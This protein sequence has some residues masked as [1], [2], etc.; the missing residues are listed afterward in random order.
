MV[1]TV[2]LLLLSMTVIGVLSL[3]VVMTRL[4][5]AG[6][7]RESARALYCAEAGLAMG[8]AQAA[9]NVGQWNRY[10]ACNAEGGCPAGYPFSGAAA[11]DGSAAF[12]VRVEDNVDEFPPLQNDPRADADLTVV[13]VS[14]CTDPLL[15]PRV[16]RQYIV[17]DVRQI[18]DYRSQ[19]GH[20]RAGAGN[21]N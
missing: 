2:M 5:S 16:L 18:P 10:L 19:R 7:Q 4:R 14:R 21:Q 8:R 3:N 11:S 17:Y 6:A 20:G 12:E 9:A 13:L 15:P 1:A